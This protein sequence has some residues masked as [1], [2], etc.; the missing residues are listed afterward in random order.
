MAR[1]FKAKKFG[2]N[3]K[4]KIMDWITENWESMSI[5]LVTIIQSIKALILIFR[6][7]K[8]Q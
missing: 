7:P 4:T 8:Q 6:K 2:T 5:A 1:L 3:Y